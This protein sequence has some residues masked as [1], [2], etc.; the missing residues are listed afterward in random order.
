MDGARQA[1]PPSSPHT[2]DP[3]SS[4]S[5]HRPHRPGIFV[6]VPGLEDGEGKPSVCTV[7][8][9]L[10][11][12]VGSVLFNLIRVISWLCGLIKH[13]VSLRGH[14]PLSQRPLTFVSNSIIP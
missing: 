13:S 7:S 14:G 10:A 8:K 4:R 3:E 11:F 6:Q 1:E 9:A 12:I 2:A 5:S